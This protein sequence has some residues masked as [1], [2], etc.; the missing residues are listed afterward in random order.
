VRLRNRTNPSSCR[1]EIDAT[2]TLIN[3]HKIEFLRVNGH[4]INVQQDGMQ[5]RINGEVTKTNVVERFLAT[6]KARKF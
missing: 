6:L 5:I 2:A 4:A 3:E 1:N